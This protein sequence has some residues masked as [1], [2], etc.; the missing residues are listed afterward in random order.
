MRF[1][2]ARR[3]LI[4]AFAFA[5]VAAGPAAASAPQTVR[6]MCAG[7]AT[8]LLRYTTG[9][10]KRSERKLKPPSGGP[11]RA[12]RASKGRLALVPR[13][14]ACA[15]GQPLT[16]PSPKKTL[17]FCVKRRGGAMRLVGKHAHCRRAEFAARLPKHFYPPL[18]KADSSATDEDTAITIAVLSNDTGTGTLGV[19]SIDT[20]GTRG[21]ATVGLNGKVRYDPAG[22]FDS[23]AQGATATDEFTYR[24]RSGTH[25]SSPATVRVT[26]TGRDDAPAV[27]TTTGLVDYTEG[28]A[29]VQVDGGLT[30]ADSDDASLAGATV[31]IA[32]EFQPGDQLQ[33]ANANGISGNYDSSTGVLTLTGSA[34]KDDYQSALR[35]V[36]FESTND[37][38]N[39][40][41][42]VEFRVTDGD[43]ASNAATRSLAVDPV[44]DAPTVT[45]SAGSPT[46]IE[47]AP[48]TAVDASLTVA[49]P[50]DT[51]IQSAVVSI[52]TGFQAGDHLLFVDQNGISGSYNSGTGVLTLTNAASKADYQTAL[53][54]IQFS[55]TTSDPSRSRTVEFKV[56]DGDAFSNPATRSVTVDKPPVVTTSAGNTNGVDTG[57]QPVDPGVTVSDPDDTNLSS[58]S[59][60]ISGGFQAGDQLLFSTQNG[61]TGNY[62]AG[63][64]VLTLTGPSSVANYQTALRSV[65]F[66]NT[67]T[68][69]QRTIEFKVNDGAADSNAATKLFNV[70]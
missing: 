35:S 1:R 53:R 19:A 31:R 56:H 38:P 33:F 59:V 25:T 21:S 49:D 65:Q 66:H 17:R 36:H 20:T 52:S 46:F 11:V 57:T 14:A 39:T 69:T 43:L 62:D 48:A 26:L 2:V 18:A 40:S 7:K 3:L 8:G 30:L 34:S 28:G 27:T 6:A 45:T 47:G 29:P 64:G 61:I 15:V 22:Q 37:D 70:N 44:N 4:T 55:T 58:A 41:R 67:V 63:T 32:T 60:R 68:G 10:C 12:C 50:D 51:T 23:L 24:V 54:S 42:T 16:L 9:G 13:S 5:L